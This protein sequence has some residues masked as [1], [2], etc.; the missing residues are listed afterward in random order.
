VVIQSLQNGLTTNQQTIPVGWTIDGVTQTTQISA[1]LQEGLNTI[2]RSSTDQFGRTGAASVQVTL[3]RQASVVVLTSPVNGTVT[4]Q[5]DIAVAWTVDG[6]T[7][8]TDL[9]ATLT[10]GVNTIARSYTDAAGNTGTASI[11]VTLDTQVPVVVITSPANGTITNQSE[12]VIA[13]AVDGVAQT[14]ELTASLIEG[15]NTITRSYTDAAG[16]VGTAS[17]Q[18]ILDTQAL[19]VAITSPA[20]GTITNQSESVIAWTVDGVAQTTE[21]TASLTESEN[22]ITQRF[23]DAAGNTGTTS[24][25][26]TLDTQKPVVI[27]VSPVENTIS[28]FPGFCCL[29]C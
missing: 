9:T 3:D 21:L 1:S 7:Q 28:E 25:Q 12:T 13:W 23:T 20:N 15:E 10:E 17:I 24:I 16:N 14:T 22:T 11:Q 6:V 4:N 29:D 8:T 27:I 2:N 18:V 26:V 5:S 19:V